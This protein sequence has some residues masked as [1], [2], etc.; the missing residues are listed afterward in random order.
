MAPT[1]ATS[2]HPERHLPAAECLGDRHE[3]PPPA[4]SSAGARHDAERQGGEDAEPEDDPFDI[5]T[6]AR[7]GNP[8]R[9][10]SRV[11][12]VGG[13]TVRRGSTSRFDRELTSMRTATFARTKAATAAPLTGELGRNAQEPAAEPGIPGMRLGEP[14]GVPPADV[15]RSAA[16]AERALKADHRQR[17]RRDERDQQAVATTCL[18]VPP[19]RCYVRAR[20]RAGQTADVPSQRVDVCLAFSRGKGLP[21]DAGVGRHESAP[22]ADR[23]QPR[24]RNLGDSAVSASHGWQRWQP[25]PVKA[26]P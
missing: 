4:P 14:E 15:H 10:E 19:R 13:I 1:T 7:D 21:A 16:S 22:A 23:R 26:S 3:R 20:L 8:P 24:R 11:L 17:V 6:T 18:R 5:D 12:L 9:R 2:G 25:R